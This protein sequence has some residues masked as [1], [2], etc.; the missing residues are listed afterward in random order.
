[1]KL[2]WSLLAS[3]LVVPGYVSAQAPTKADAQKWSDARNA[4]RNKGDWAAYAQFFTT[5]ASVVTSDGS[6]YSG[7]AEIQ[8]RTQDLYGSGAYKGV[9]T[10]GTVV[11]VWAISP[12]VIVT[13]GTFEL[14]NIP[15]GG[16]RKGF[17]TTVLVK[18]GSDWKVGATRSMVPAK[19]GAL[20]T[21][22]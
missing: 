12:D 18:Q 17:T 3:L 8:K 5:D 19:L 14:A 9:Q 10:T 11:A 4:A 7:R 20:P 15:G 16:T 2:A 21:Q 6:S 22:K 13:D 1:M